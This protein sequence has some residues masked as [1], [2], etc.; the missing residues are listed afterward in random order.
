MGQNNQILNQGGSGMPSKDSR[1][2]AG[3]IFWVVILVLMMSGLLVQPSIS[4]A[5]DTPPDNPAE[6]VETKVDLDSMSVDEPA[7]DN[8]NVVL[9]EQQI[10][11][12]NQSLKNSIEENKQLMFDKEKALSDLK[13][14]RGQKEVDANRITAL[15]QERDQLQKKTDELSKSNEELTKQINQ[16]QTSLDQGKKEWTAKLKKVED[17]LNLEEQ[18]HEEMEAMPV[19]TKETG[20]MKN[21]DLAEN[22]NDLTIKE[23]SLKLEK[24]DTENE[25]LKRE[26]A[27]VHYNLGNIFFQQGDYERSAVEYKKAADF[28]PYDAAVHYNL[29]FVTGEY[30]ND[31]KTALKNY[32]QYLFLNPKA[33]D[34]SFVKEK[35]LKARMQLRSTIDSPLEKKTILDETP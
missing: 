2:S 22:C 16:L 20:L 11:K 29:A 34:A 7:V 1:D 3:S 28:M 9:D 14:L 15:T 33:K 5:Q 21:K 32:E 24:S 10:L 8:K 35:I 19:P 6:V 27:Q 17:Q 26:S 30:L 23:L 13:V 31:Q 4:V 12:M 18:W 25:K